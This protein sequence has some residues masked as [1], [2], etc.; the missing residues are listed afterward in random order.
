MLLSLSNIGGVGYGLGQNSNK[1]LVMSEMN[2]RCPGK[3]DRRFMTTKF[4]QSQPQLKM[5]VQ[6]KPKGLDIY[7]TVL[8]DYGEI[9]GK[10]NP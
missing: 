10:F 1:Q 7:S 2:G 4:L 6:I 9:K 5:T 3:L 8:K